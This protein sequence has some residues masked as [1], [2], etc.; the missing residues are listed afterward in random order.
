VDFNRK[1]GK[2][3]THDAV[4]KLTETFKKTGSVTDKLRSGLP[5][6]SADEGTANVVLGAFA[7]SLQKST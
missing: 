5:L 1:H 7:R 2:N 3:I 6:T 4:A